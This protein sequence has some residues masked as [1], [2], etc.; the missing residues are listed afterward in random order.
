MDLLVLGDTQIATP[1]GIYIDNRLGNFATS[2]RAAYRTRLGE[3]HGYDDSHRELLRALQTQQAQHRN[4]ENGYW[5]AE[6]VPDAAFHAMTT[7][8]PV[9][10]TPWLVLATDGAYKTMA[11]LGLD[12]WDA[13]AGLEQPELQ[14][15][16]TD[17]ERW[18][19]ND[20]PLGLALPRAKCHDD[21][22]LASV[23]L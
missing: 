17:L 11:H 8:L 18:E 13:V 14:Q 5:I 20:D 21:K 2:E 3:G 22:T 16:L 1:S 4:R 19:A 9:A 15:L 7:T 6:A 12:D 10:S 23:K